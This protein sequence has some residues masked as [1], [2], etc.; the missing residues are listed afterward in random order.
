MKDERD[1]IKDITEMRSMMER[2]SKFMSL[3]GL[4]GVMAGIYAITGAILVYKVFNF[5][6]DKVI[7][8]QSELSAFGDRLLKIVL[9]AVVVLILAVGT[10]ILLSQQKANK[11]GE[12]F[13]NSTTRRMA[14]SMFIP[15]AAG[16]IL[17]LVLI[18]KG[19]IGWI[20]P[21][22]LIFYGLALYNAGQFTYGEM[23]SLGLIQVLLGIGSVYFV[24][25][26]LLCWA[27]GFGVTHIIYGIYMH[28]Q[29]ER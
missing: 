12:K 29:Y 1:Y 20:A 6:P 15:L 27:V 25:Y 9:L 3:S 4:S 2:S 19:F 8:S 26:G 21:F 7:Y 23:K 11:S 22:S 10:S 18:S 16:G 17:M 28:Y 5:N 24:E 14:M 13:W